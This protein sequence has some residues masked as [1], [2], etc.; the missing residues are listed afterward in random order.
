M[1]WSN[2]RFGAK[3]AFGLSAVSGIIAVTQDGPITTKLTFVL[4]ISLLALVFCWLLSF[5]VYFS[6]R[7]EADYAERIFKVLGFKNPSIVNLTPFSMS[8]ACDHSAG[9]L[10]YIFKLR[11]ALAAYGSLSKARPDT[12]KPKAQAK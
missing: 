4:F 1:A 6:S 11:E 5:F 9:G 2:I 7:H 3:L 12:A 8:V 10:H